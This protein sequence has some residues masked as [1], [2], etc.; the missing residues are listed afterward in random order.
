MKMLLRPDNSIM[1]A[2]WAVEQKEGER[3]EKKAKR[4]VFL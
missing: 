4:F 3:R 1:R 2:I